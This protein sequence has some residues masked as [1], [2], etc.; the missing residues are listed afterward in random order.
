[1]FAVPLQ[2]AWWGKPITRWTPQVSM[3]SLMNGSEH[4]GIEAA[5]DLGFS[6][7]QIPEIFGD[8][9]SPGR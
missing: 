6:Y 5:S 7:T 2:L 4:D 3:G 9:R 1:M 8:N